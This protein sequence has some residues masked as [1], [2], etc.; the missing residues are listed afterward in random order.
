M[1]FGKLKKCAECTLFPKE[2]QMR[3]RS[4][5][6][7]YFDCHTLWPPHTL[8]GSHL[9]FK[10]PFD[11]TVLNA[12]TFRI[13]IFVWSFK[14]KVCDNSWLLC[15]RSAHYLPLRLNWL[16]KQKQHISIASFKIITMSKLKTQHINVFIQL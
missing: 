7:N 13:V 2:S 6:D 5:S 14:L 3:V 15:K 1:Y 8:E 16:K 11:L 10:I 4:A 12:A 9:Q